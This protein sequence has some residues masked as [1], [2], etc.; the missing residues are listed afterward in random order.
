MTAT[1]LAIS[2]DILWKV[3]ESRGY[4]PGPLFREAGLDPRLA[5]DPNAR[6]PAAQVERLTIRTHELLADPCLG[7]KAV[8]HWHPSHLGALG[9]AWLAS[10]TL[11]TALQRLERYLKLVT[12]IM[13]M[14]L[15]QRSGTVTVAFAAR[16]GYRDLP[17]RH[18]FFAGLVLRMCRM[19]WGE[20]LAPVRVAFAHER[21]PCC[22]G[23]AEY[24]RCPVDF[25]A[26]SNS[27]VFA[28]E[29]VDRQL[30]SGNPQLAQVHDQII[31]RYLAA[32]DRSDVVQQTKGLILDRLQAGGVAHDDVAN[33]LHLSVRTLQRKLR[34]AGTSFSTL[35]D[36]TRR[37]L[38]EA[39]IRDRSVS[40][41]ELAFML[42]FSDASAFSR[43]YKRWTG[44]TPGESRAA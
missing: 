4:D 9:Y 15:E 22:D 11:R 17:Q 39:Y 44:R 14:A 28:T 13:I 23:Y 3:I 26:A 24:F 27:M 25:G 2:A 29:A 38:A 19:N 35:V 7:L 6:I 33:A 30:T 32:L 10:S 36:E 18:D 8:R 20:D 42:G 16:P 12:A 31:I 41:S 37:E 5:R 40:L 21:Y 1:N 34:D 43:A